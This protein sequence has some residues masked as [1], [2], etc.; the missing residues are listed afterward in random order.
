VVDWIDLGY[1]D[2]EQDVVRERL[3]AML[4]SSI[5]WTEIALERLRSAM[6]EEPPL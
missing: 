1:G 4:Q 3:R 5:E 2:Y 6:K